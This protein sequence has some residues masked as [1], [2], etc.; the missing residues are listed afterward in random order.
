[1]G[2]TSPAGRASSIDYNEQCLPVLLSVFG[3][4]RIRYEYDRF[5]NV[6]QVSGAA[7]GTVAFS[8][9]EYGYRPLAVTDTLGHSAACEHDDNGR[10]T[11][12]RHPDG[13]EKRLL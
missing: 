12:H 1:M 3:G 9:D 13:A 6:V 5:G 10:L 11:A 7:G 4:Q 8:Y 2:I